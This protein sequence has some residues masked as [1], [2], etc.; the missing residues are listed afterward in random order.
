[1]AKGQ[2]ALIA[3]EE[4]KSSTSI[5]IAPKEAARVLGCSPMS[6]RLQAQEDPAKLGFPVCR[7]GTVTMIPRVP[8]L[9]WVTGE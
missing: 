2:D 1:M 8:F 9:R 4:L 6:I 7:M 5:V 3:L